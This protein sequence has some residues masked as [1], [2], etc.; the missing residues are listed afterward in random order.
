MILLCYLGLNTQTTSMVDVIKV[1][2][3]GSINTMKTLT[4][5]IEAVS[6]NESETHEWNNKFD[7]V[8]FD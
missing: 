8:L 4:S 6:N 2:F 3:S 1:L 5:T 7:A